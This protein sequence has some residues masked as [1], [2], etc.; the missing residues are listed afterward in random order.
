MGRAEDH[1]L[2]LEEAR[3]VPTFVRAFESAH[4]D[5][6]RERGAQPV[7]FGDAAASTFLEW[8]DRRGWESPDE[9]DDEEFE[10]VL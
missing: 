9:L 8:Y 10:D 2:L 7:G 3:G 6:L 4:A 5:W 1:A